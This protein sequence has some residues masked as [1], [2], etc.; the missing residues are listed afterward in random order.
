LTRDHAGPVAGSLGNCLGGGLP[1]ERAFLETRFPGANTL[2][3]G[4]RLVALTDGLYGPLGQDELDR[5]TSLHLEEI[6]GQARS[7]VEA[8][9]APDN[10]SLII[11][12]G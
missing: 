4:Q 9:G 8:N 11:V 6:P 12:E 10:Y 2:L 3:P 7:L 1:P 5:L